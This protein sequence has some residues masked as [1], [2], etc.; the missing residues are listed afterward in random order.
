VNKVIARNPLSGQLRH[1]S[2]TQ[3]LSNTVHE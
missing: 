2:F 3:L 1:Y